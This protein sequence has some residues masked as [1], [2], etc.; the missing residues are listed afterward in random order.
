MNDQRETCIIGDVHGMFDTLQELL[1]TINFDPKKIRLIFLGDLVDRGEKSAECVQLVRSLCEKGEAE[2]VL[3]NHEAKHIRY[4]GHE[5]KKALTG[6]N[7]PMK[8]MSPIDLEAHNKLSDEDIAWMRKLPL[9]IHIKD[10]FYAIH[11]GLEP[12]YTFDKQHPDQIIRCRYVSDGNYTT[13]NGKVIGRGK[14]VPLAAD[15][16]QQANTVYWTDL[17]DGPESIIFGHSVN[18]LHT[19]LV[20]NRPNGVKCIGIDLGAVFGGHL[21]GYF[22]ERNEF[23]K[24]KAKRAYHK[25]DIQ[26]DD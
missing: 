4:R 20:V 14:S 26:F 23:V 3:A 21:C 13:S 19:P 5:I 25:L 15:M 10:N 17:W 2:C 11:A 8:P 9:T 6:K 22:L 7:N 1:S 18:S 16:K 24:V 12:A